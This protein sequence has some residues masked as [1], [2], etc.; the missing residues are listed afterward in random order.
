MENLKLFVDLV[1]CPF[2]QTAVPIPFIQSA[3]G[4]SLIPPT[5]TYQ[6]I[7]LILLQNTREKIYCQAFRAIY[8][9]CQ[10]LH[11]IPVFHIQIMRKEELEPVACIPIYLLACAPPA[12][13]VIHRPLVFN[14]QRSRHP[15]PSLLYIK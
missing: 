10:Q 14:P 8:L 2:F 11:P 15:I 13:H 5:C 12:H 3:S 7:S 4:L 1:V 6:D 9:I